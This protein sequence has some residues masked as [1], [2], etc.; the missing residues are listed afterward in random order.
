[1]KNSFITIFILLLLIF[2][3]CKKKVNTLPPYLTKGNPEYIINEGYMYLNQGLLNKSEERFKKALREIP[4]H[5]KALNGLGII[6]LK[7]KKFDKSAM[8]FKKIL[9]YNQSQVDANNFL[10]IIYSEKGEYE[11]AKENFLIAAN[12]PEYKTPENAYQNL[13][14]LEIKR[15]KTDSALRYIE[16][17]I[18]KNRDFAGLYAVR[19]MIFDAKKLYRKALYNF[20]KALK[21]SKVKSFNLK[22]NVARGYI[23]T[24]QRLLALNLLEKM[25]AEASSEAERAIVRKMMKSLE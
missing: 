1:M 6:Y 22:M 14:L 18:L 9:K 13:A 3:A 25:I 24:G 21:L 23:K 5:L 12:T 7:Q 19:G 8:Q 15:G 16:K 11:K 17:G 4:N 10:G 20:E 2:P